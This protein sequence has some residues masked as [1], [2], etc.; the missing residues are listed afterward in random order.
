M[1]ILDGFGSATPPKSQRSSSSCNRERC[2]FH[3][4]SGQRQSE[5]RWVAQYADSLSIASAISSQCLAALPHC[6]AVMPNLR[7]SRLAPA[8]Q[9]LARAGA[10]VIIRLAGQAPH[11]RSGSAQTLGSTREHRWC[12]Q[13]P[14]AAVAAKASAVFLGFAMAEEQR[15]HRLACRGQLQRLWLA[16]AFQ[17]RFSCW[18]ASRFPA[19]RLSPSSAPQ[20]IFTQSKPQV[21]WWS[22]SIRP[23]KRRGQHAP[24]AHQPSTANPVQSWRVRAAGRR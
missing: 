23:T 9:T 22:Q 2:S 19:V 21:A 24:L 11:R 13:R 15:L 18:L 6:Y 4:G 12:S 16:A 7:W 8:W 10:S 20:R 14:T 17:V 5:Q 3:V 1:E